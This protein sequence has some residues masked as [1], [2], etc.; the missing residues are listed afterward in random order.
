M[1]R[2]IDVLVTQHSKWTA[3]RVRRALFGQSLVDF[4]ADPWVAVKGQTDSKAASANKK[5]GNK[6]SRLEREFSQ[7]QSSSSQATVIVES[8]PADEAFSSPETPAGTV[9]FSN[10]SSSFQDFSGFQ[11]QNFHQ[12]FHLHFPNEPL[13]H[14]FPTG[15]LEP[16]V[17]QDAFL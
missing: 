4:T 10:D 15:F 9:Y 11:K 1:F 8:T 14:Y 2:M 16:F 6:Q 5:V 12:S 13:E 3:R 7:S 17:S